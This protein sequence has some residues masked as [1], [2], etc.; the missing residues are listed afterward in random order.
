[1]LN[2]WRLQVNTQVRIF[3]VQTFSKA[4]IRRTTR[5]LYSITKSPPL[6]TA[7]YSII[8]LVELGRR[9]E[10]EIV[11]AYNRREKELEQAGSVD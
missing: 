3:N 11:Q 6:S 10:N 1:M 7:M 2:S 4:G 9:G 5:R 8:Q